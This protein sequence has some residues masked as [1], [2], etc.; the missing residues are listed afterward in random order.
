MIIAIIIGGTSLTG[1]EGTV[2]GMVIGAFI[3]GFLSNVL[4]LLGMQAFYQDVVKGLVLVFA[5]LMDI[6]IRDRIK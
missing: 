3:V 4:N 2:I 6:V 5:V 1:G